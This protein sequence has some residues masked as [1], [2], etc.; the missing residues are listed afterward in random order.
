MNI[1]VMGT[2]LPSAHGLRIEALTGASVYKLC[3]LG[4]TCVLLGYE[5]L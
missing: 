5:G 3:L 1:L 4:A 2:E